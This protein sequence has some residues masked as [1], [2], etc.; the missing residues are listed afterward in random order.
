MT[1]WPLSL[2]F[3]SRWQQFP[4][5]TDAA[6][7]KEQSK[8]IKEQQ[9]RE[10]AVHFYG[11]EYVRYVEALT[12]VRQR[13]RGLQL[14]NTSGKSQW[15]LASLEIKVAAAMSELERLIANPVKPKSQEGNE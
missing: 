5:A 8:F 15:E 11:D 13:L 14:A 12:N 4:S 2:F 7:R 9:E 6:V 10:Q 1:M 3:G